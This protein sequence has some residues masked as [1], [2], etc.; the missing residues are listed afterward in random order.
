MQ[1]IGVRPDRGHEVSSLSATDVCGSARL[2]GEQLDSLRACAKGIS[3]RFEKSEIV[4]AL[5]AAG[6]A[7][8]N[9]VGVIKL[10]ASGDQHL[11]L[12]RV[13]ASSA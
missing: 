5:V 2:T 3:L 11:R 6:Y 1:A 4:N 7:E 9:I 8:R 13:D 10:T 12:Q